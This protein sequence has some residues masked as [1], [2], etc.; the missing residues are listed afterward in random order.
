LRPSNALN[1]ALMRAAAARGMLWYNLGSSEGLPGVARFKD[2]L[3][4]MEIP[5]HEIRVERRPF[6]IYANVRK[7]LAARAGV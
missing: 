6:K 3:G 5:Y 7:V 4:A 1:F 2:N